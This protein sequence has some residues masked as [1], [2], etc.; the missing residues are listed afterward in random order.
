MMTVLMMTALALLIAG[1]RLEQNALLW[2]SGLAY[3][4]AIVP[5]LARRD[6]PRPSSGPVERV[7]QD[8]RGSEGQR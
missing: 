6:G 8:R 1:V 3:A 4:G 2:A 7:R 5:V